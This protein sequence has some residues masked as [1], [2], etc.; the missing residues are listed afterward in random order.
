MNPSYY[1]K[2]LINKNFGE[3]FSSLE[4]LDLSSNMLTEFP[5][6]V[7]E[8]SNLKILRLIFNKIKT[9]PIEFYKSDK[10]GSLKELNL[11]SNPL[12]ELNPAIK[13]LKDLRILGISYTKVQEIPPQITALE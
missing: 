7:K 6:C 10:M 12:V 11:D 9:I 5:I 13:Q 8:C 3:T 4:L 1:D 2:S